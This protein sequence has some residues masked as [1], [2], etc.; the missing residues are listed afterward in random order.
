MCEHSDDF[1]IPLSDFNIDIVKV[2]MRK[3]IRY[4]EYQDLRVQYGI[5]AIQE[6]ADIMVLN[7]MAYVTGK[8]VEKIHIDVEY[9]AD[10]WEAFKDRWF[11]EFMP[12]RW[13]VKVTRI[14]V[15]EDRYMIC[16]HLTTEPRMTHYKWLQ[17]YEKVRDSQT[18]S[19]L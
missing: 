14:K 5:E 13:P 3:A 1:A 10:W 6:S 9:P 11:P 4:E 8:I 17:S 2:S 15:N 19:G 16:P 18:A 7:L 12:K